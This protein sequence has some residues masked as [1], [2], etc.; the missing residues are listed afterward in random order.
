LPKSLILGRTGLGSLLQLRQ[1]S[2]Q[3]LAHIDDLSVTIDKT[4]RKNASYVQAELSTRGA[5]LANELKHAL[6]IDA[7]ENTFTRCLNVGGSDTATKE[8]HFTKGFPLP[9]RSYKLALP[10]IVSLVN[11]DFSGNNKVKVVLLLPVG[12]KGFVIGK[13]P[14]TR[15]LESLQVELVDICA[16]TLKRHFIACF[17]HVFTMQQFHGCSSPIYLLGFS[18]V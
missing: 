11:A 5:T 8:S 18:S 17:F 15:E 12:D 6:V 10:L 14:F 1:G 3:L 13:H 7:P 9:K 2:L 4:I 16:Q